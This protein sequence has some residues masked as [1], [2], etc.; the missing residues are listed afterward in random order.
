MPPG[1]TK[2]SRPGD[3]EVER[4][5]KESLTKQWFLTKRQLVKIGDWK[6]RRGERLYRS[7]D[8]QGRWRS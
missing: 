7:N 2:R 1:T 6:S 8:T 3:R 5:M 4:L